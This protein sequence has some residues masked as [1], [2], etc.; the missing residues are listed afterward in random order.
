[1][2][3]CWP[4]SAARM[5]RRICGGSAARP[6]RPTKT[7]DRV[8][9]HPLFAQYVL[10][11]I[12]TSQRRTRA[13]RAAAAL[14][15]S[16]L[17]A[18]AFDLVQRYAPDLALAD[19][20]SEGLSLLDA[21]CWISVKDAVRALPQSVRRDDPIVVCLRAELEAQT[22]A[23]ERRQ[24]SLRQS[25]TSDSHHTRIR[26]RVCRHRALHYLNQGNGEALDVIFPVL[27]IRLGRSTA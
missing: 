19:L 8:L 18:R 13:L 16:G 6:F 24:R 5:R 1:M 3:R 12:P 23:L 26:A 27:D 22:G 2:S 21:G 20:H 25:R 17:V 14:R 9:L 10:A 11:Q 7:G 15:A 4:R